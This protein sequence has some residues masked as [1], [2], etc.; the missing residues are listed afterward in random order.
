[1][2]MITFKGYR[3]RAEHTFRCPSCGKPN[4]KRSFVEEHTVNPFNKNA[5]GSAKQAA[6]VQREAIEDAKRHRDQFAAEP[7][8]KTC[9][10]ALSGAER[11]SLFERRRHAVSTASP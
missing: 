2:S 3:G 1:M 6:Q 11:Q 5:D 4:R 10:D 8:C 9:E 7:L